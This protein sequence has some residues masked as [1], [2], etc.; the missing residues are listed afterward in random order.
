LSSPWRLC[1]MCRVSPKGPKKR[2][3]KMSKNISQN[4]FFA[5]TLSLSLFSFSRALSLSL[6]L[7][8]SPTHCPVPTHLFMS[9][10]F[11]LCFALS[12]YLAVCLSALLENATHTACK[13]K[14][15]R[16]RHKNSILCQKG[17]RHANTST[18]VQAVLFFLLYKSLWLNWCPHAV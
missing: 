4:I 13:S 8:L 12:F 6:F 10:S 18:K 9:L 17:G 2:V 15:S 16:D 14:A 5:H 11:S 1:A 7:S 3:K